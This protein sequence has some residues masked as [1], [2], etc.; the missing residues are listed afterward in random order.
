[1][2]GDK[3]NV[4]TVISREHLREYANTVKNSDL[5]RLLARWDGINPPQNETLSPGVVQ[6]S[7]IAA[8]STSAA[9]PSEIYAQAITQYLPSGVPSLLLK[10]GWILKF[11]PTNPIGQKPIS[12]NSDGN[13]GVGK[14][15]NEFRWQMVN[16]MLEIVRQN[17]DLQNRFK[18]DPHGE[19]FLCTNDVDAKGYKDQ[20]IYRDREV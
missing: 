5:I 3:P 16:G 9:V 15:K 4:H 14:N 1:M 12:F 18:Y 11:N 13:I 6:Q 20:F 2:A 17:N 7:K 19:K 8:Q 10:D